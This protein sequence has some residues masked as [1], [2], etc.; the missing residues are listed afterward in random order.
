MSQLGSVV[1]WG[2]IGSG[3]VE[4]WVPSCVVKEGGIF[5][6]IVGAIVWA[7]GGR[8]PYSVSGIDGGILWTWG[9]GI[10][11][12]SCRGKEAAVLYS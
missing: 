6:F 7:V 4:E 8:S 1:E 5:L 2:F 12:G 3:K 10:S 11:E 9:E